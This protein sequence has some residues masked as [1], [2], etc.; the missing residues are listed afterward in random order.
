MAKTALLTAAVPGD[1]ETS[2]FAFH[3][4]QSP[5]PMLAIALDEVTKSA[6][7]DITSA[8]E[9]CPEDWFGIPGLTFEPEA[10]DNLQMMFVFCTNKLSN[11]S[12]KDSKALQQRLLD[13][14]DVYCPD[15]T[16]DALTCRGLEL[17]GHDRTQLIARFRAPSWLVQM[18]RSIWRACREFGVAY[19]DAMWFPYI[20]LGRLKGSRSQLDQVSFKEVLQIDI[21]A[22]RLTLLGKHPKH[23]DWHAL[24]FQSQSSGYPPPQASPSVAKQ[25]FHAGLDHASPSN[26]A[27]Q[28]ASED[29][30]P[31]QSA[32]ATANEVLKPSRKGGNTKSQLIWKFQRPTNIEDSTPDQATSPASEGPAKENHH[33]GLENTKLPSLKIASTSEQVLWNKP[34]G[35]RSRLAA[36]I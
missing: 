32:V 14:F 8:M 15:I 24:N 3:A 10:W 30:A 5:K 4:S 12:L 34:T 9:R 28:G 36:P 23:G 11:L 16:S 7:L 25:T 29:S 2:G 17:F 27:I 1:A 18:R 20:Q 6:L 31:G 21:R 33:A 35:G 26:A 13:A 19:P 22:T